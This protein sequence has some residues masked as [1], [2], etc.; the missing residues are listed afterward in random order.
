[1]KILIL[2]A[3]AVGLS[4]AARL[5]HH[6]DVTAITRSIYV[7]EINEKGLKLTGTWENESYSFHCTDILPSDQSYDFIIITTKAYDTESICE[8]YSDLIRYHTVLTFQ[9]GVGNAETI[10]RYTHKV[11]S[12][13]VYTGFVRISHSEIFINATSRSWKIGNYSNVDSTEISQIS[14]CFQ[15]SGFNI[16]QDNSILSHVWSKNLISSALNPLSALLEVPF[17]ELIKPDIWIYIKDIAREYY[18][19][20]HEQGPELLWPDADSFLNFLKTEDIPIMQNHISSM[21]QDIRKRKRTEIDFMNGAII[22]A[23]IDLGIPTPMNNLISRLIKEKEL[24]ITEPE[25]ILEILKR[26]YKNV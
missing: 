10:A 2:G 22:R 24:H 9:N 25:K 13:V 18:S 23:G 5:S 21:L 26:S 1:M 17:G 15:K 8:Q 4:I 19:I 12:G 16:T 20:I 7:R 6:A 11:I 14:E 3:G